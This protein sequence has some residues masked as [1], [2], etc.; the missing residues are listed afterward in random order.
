MSEN[1][2]SDLKSV[3]T[4]FVSVDRL[5]ILRHRVNQR[6]DRQHHA[7]HAG[8]ADQKNSVAQHLSHRLTPIPHEVEVQRDH[9]KQ[10]GED[11]T[12]D[13]TDV[14]RSALKERKLAGAVRRADIT[15]QVLA[16]RRI[17]RADNSSQICK[18]I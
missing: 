13:I 1:N 10:R 4:T 3:E 18:T 2:R 12:K 5:E 6:V 15:I 14:E 16:A 17:R 9:E 7:C 8:H 11:L